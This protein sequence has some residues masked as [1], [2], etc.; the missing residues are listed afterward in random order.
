MVIV[1]PDK[2]GTKRDLSVLTS[3]RCLA[4]SLT[5]IMGSP[6]V[7]VAHPSN[8]KCGLWSSLTCSSTGALACWSDFL[9][10]SWEQMFNV[11]TEVVDVYRLRRQWWRFNVITDGDGCLV[12]SWTIH[13]GWRVCG[14]GT[15]HWLW[16]QNWSIMPFVSSILAAATMF[17]RELLVKKAVVQLHFRKCLAL[18][19]TR[20]TRYAGRDKSTT[21]EVYCRHLWW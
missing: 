8:V 17:H 6:I 14:A 9:C 1:I 16:L 13:C 11:A 3:V 5:D 7:A 12:S 18:S 4:S 19:P 2:L 20:L 15:V 10:S 21:S